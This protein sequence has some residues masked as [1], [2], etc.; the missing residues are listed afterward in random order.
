MKPIFLRNTKELRKWLEINHLIKTELWLGFYKTK[1]PKFNYS[2][3]DTVDE[4]ICF[5]WID[6]IRK[7]IDEE[8]YM[9]RITPRKPTSNW[10]A[11]NIEKANRLIKLNLMQESGLKAFN[12]RCKDK[13]KVYSFEQGK[14]KLPDHYD[15]EI[16]KNE[17]GWKFYNSLSS[18]IKKQCCYWI[19][20][21]KKKE[22]QLKRLQILIDSSNKEEKIPQ[23]NWSKKKPL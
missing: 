16:M 9:I 4:L 19:M 1:S 15:Q 7:S 11:I 8:S 23:L 6:G 2:W 18:S 17:K 21:A 14:V 22:T 20:S 5:G 13:S 12:L 10:S 3:S